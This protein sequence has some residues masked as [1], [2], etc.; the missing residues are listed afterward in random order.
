MRDGEK[1][2]MLKD[3]V[4]SIL[5]FVVKVAD[6]GCSTP[7]TLK[8]ALGVVG[9]LVMAFQQ[10]LTSY[11]RDAPF[12]SKLVT[13]GSSLGGRDPQVAQTTQWLQRLFAR[14]GAQ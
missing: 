6:D 5:E 11:L 8:S 14:Y 13:L 7:N 9:D 1:L 12:L 10:Q 2:D 4:Q 3:Y